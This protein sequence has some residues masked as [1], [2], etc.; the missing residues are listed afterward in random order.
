[1]ST[2]GERNTVHLFFAVGSGIGP[3]SRAPV[4]FAG[5]DD[6]GRRLIED[7]VVVCL[8][9]ECGSSRRTL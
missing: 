4:R 1:L 6:L 2:C 7:A 5:V 3:A 8:Q 9:G